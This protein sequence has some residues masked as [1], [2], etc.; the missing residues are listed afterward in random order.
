MGVA[1]YNGDTITCLLAR[2][3]T[4]VTPSDL[5]VRTGTVV[6]PLSI[7]DRGLEAR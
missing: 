2:P 1:G 3:V 5:L 6:T 7:G 4:V